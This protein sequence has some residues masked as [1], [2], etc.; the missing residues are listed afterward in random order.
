MDYYAARPDRVPPRLIRPGN[1]F[2]VPAGRTRD[3]R[4]VF[5][6]Y[7]PN[8]DRRAGVG[9]LNEL[10]QVGLAVGG[11]VAGSVNQGGGGERA[12][13]QAFD[14]QAK[15]TTALFNSI[16]NSGRPITA[17][18]LA[19]AEQELGVLYSIVQQAPTPNITGQWESPSYRPV[20]EARLQQIRQAAA[21]TAAGAGGA[22][23]GA[24]GVESPAGAHAGLPFWAIPVA[25][26]TGLYFL[27]GRRQR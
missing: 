4:Q 7:A 25:V 2:Y 16:Q 23:G 10:I 24:G 5:K 18:D 8:P 15:K 11:M 26:G 14:A 3:G 6:V 12:A 27:L 21:Q 9:Y 22:G 1:R 20:Y 19:A 13:A 17:A